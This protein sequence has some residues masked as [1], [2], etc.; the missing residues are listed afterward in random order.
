MAS[1]LP[2]VRYKATVTAR[3][4]SHANDGVY[5]LSTQVMA[6]TR[7]QARAMAR[8]NAGNAGCIVIGVELQAI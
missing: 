3:N 6:S 1:Q 5:V 2:L 8:K 4:V 7:S